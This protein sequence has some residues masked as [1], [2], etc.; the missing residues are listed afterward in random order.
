MTRLIQKSCL[1]LLSAGLFFTMTGFACAANLVQYWQFEE[2][3]AATATNKL[4]SGNLAKLI[5]VDTTESW[6]VGD[7]PGAVTHSTASV[8]LDGVDDY[9]NLGN[10]RLNGAATLSMWVK[11]AGYVN[12]MRLFSPMPIP[13]PVGGVIRVDPFASGY[14]QVNSGGSWHNLAPTD[15][16]PAG[17]WTHLAFAYGNGLV[18]M[19]VNGVLL[20]INSATFAFDRVDFCL[21]QIYIASGNRFSGAFDEVSVWDG[22]LSASSIQQLAAG[23]AATAI[24]D[25]PPPL[26]PP[27]KLVQYFPLN[28]GMGS[29]TAANSVPNGTPGNLVNFDAST[30]W[31]NSG[32][33]AQLGG[34]AWA[35]S[36]DPALSNR[37]DLGEFGLVGAGTISLWMR[38]WTNSG[39]IRIY[40][41]TT[42]GVGLPG[43]V[44]IAGVGGLETW[45]GALWTRIAP[46][47][48]VPTNQ[49]THLA[50]S[51]SKGTA[52][53]YINGVPQITSRAGFLF[54]KDNFG[55]GAQG[56]LLYG[57]PYH[58]EMDDI[59]VWDQALAPATIQQ[60]A[61][62]VSPLQIVDVQQPEPPIVLSSRIVS[63]TPPILR[64]YFPMEGPL[65]STNVANFVSGTSDGFLVNYT[66]EATSWVTTNISSKLP[67]STTALFMDGLTNYANLRNL[68]LSGAGTVS[69]W[70]NPATLE[71]FGTSGGGTRRL[72]SPLAGSSTQ[73]G[74]LG[75]NPDGGIWVAGASGVGFVLAPEALG[76]GNWYH[77]AVTYSGGLA[78]VYINGVEQMTGASGLGF[79]ANAAGLG[80]RFGNNFGAT[81][82]GLMDDVAFWNG[83]LTTTSIKQLASGVSPANI[84][85]PGQNLLLSWPT[86]PGTFVLETADD[87]SGTWRT[88]HRTPVLATDTYTVTVPILPDSPGQF[89]RLRKF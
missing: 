82:S 86:Y 70:V 17:Q 81:F 80:A 43:G 50:V 39:D 37:V 4:P 68:G 61:L 23:V 5:N 52:T 9:I 88:L 27:G 8:N 76:T 18:R 54:D 34:N 73:Q 75:F 64:H 36:F 56:M 22:P 55:L 35:L 63:G 49:W 20:G 42:G 28:D 67:H 7:A 32:L 40:S 41:Q 1:A 58:G 33:A 71:T 13:V 59:S 38:P 25:V 66:N 12:D 87:L 21:G 48:A 69:M 65:D 78:T 30:A 84:V 31:I 26:P 29:Y 83:P 19:Y 51:Y 60:L 62:G 14:F 3:G 16:V 72:L 45:D 15:S 44:R 2:V 53:A 11:P 24:V 6:L 89:Y 79:A 47:G 46:D 10:L 85:E 57:R 77:V 74:A